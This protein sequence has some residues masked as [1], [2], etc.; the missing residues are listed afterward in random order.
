MKRLSLTAVLATGL[1]FASTASAHN[2]GDIVVRAGVAVVQ[3][4]A[5]SAQLNSSALGDLG[6]PAITVS[7]I[8]RNI[9]LGLTGTYMVMNHLGLEVLAATP[10]SHDVEADELSQLGL[11]DDVGST[12]HLPPTISLQYYPMS[13]DSAFQPYLGAGINYT[14][15]FKKEVNQELV[16]GL[17]GVTTV[18]EEY[19]LSLKDSWGWAVQAGFDYQI[20]DKLLVNAAVWH[21]AIASQATLHGQTSD[22]KIKAADVV[23]DPL[24]FAVTVGY[25]L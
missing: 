8:N 19:T 21:I 5:S 6:D 13:G 1:L 4:N 15:F 23:I 18:D 3:P 24:A 22:H 11:P 9:Q 7:G 14:M 2:P 17:N 10:F 16:D 12:M 20:N 25:K